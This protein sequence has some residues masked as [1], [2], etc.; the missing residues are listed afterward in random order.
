MIA[1]DCNFYSE[2]GTLGH[3]ISEILLRH[4]VKERELPHSL[5][6]SLRPARLMI[7]DPWDSAP[8]PED[9][10][11]DVLDNALVY[12]NHCIDQVIKLDDP[13][14]IRIEGRLTLNESPPIFGTVDFFATGKLAGEHVAVVSDAKFGSGVPHEK[15]T[16]G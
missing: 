4:W 6:E 16:Q 5:V 1:D 9:K 15:W 3:E 10:E 8:Y 2:R 11:P 12:V 13:V 7:Q 14:S